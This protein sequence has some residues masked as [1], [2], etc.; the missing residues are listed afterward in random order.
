MGRCEGMLKKR[1]LLLAN[2]PLSDSNSN[3]RTLKNFFSP[4]DR[5]FLAQIYL[6]GTPDLSACSRF[7]RVSDGEVP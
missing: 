2:N 6:Q 4:E 7:F 3:G 5:E 1:L